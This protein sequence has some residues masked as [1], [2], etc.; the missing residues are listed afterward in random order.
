M[1]VEILEILERRLRVVFLGAVFIL[2][3]YLRRRTR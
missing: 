2:D 3:V 1:R